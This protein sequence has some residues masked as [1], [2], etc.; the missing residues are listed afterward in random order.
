MRLEDVSDEVWAVPG[1]NHIIDAIVRE[2]G[3]T[4]FCKHDAAQVLAQY[5]DAVRQTWADWRE[6]AIGRQHAPI[7]WTLTTKAR[8]WE[9]LEVLPP[10]MM[11][12][13]AFLVG[14]PM[15]HDIATGAPRFSAYRQRGDIYEEADRPMTRAELRA[16]LAPRSASIAADIKSEATS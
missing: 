11:A 9:M 8:Y 10:A 5:P 6:S 1:Q 14:E 15:D 4:T 2:T 3:L 12:G 13:G 16:I 7:V